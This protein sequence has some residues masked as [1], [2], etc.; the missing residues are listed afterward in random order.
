[1]SW[2][3]GRRYGRWEGRVRAPAADPSYNA[4]MLLWP[5]ADTWPAGGEIDFMVLS[6]WHLDHFWGIESTLKHNPRLTIYAPATWRPEDRLLL[7]EKGNIQVEDHQGRSISICRNDVPHEGELI[8][9]KSEGESGEGLYRLLPGVALRMFDALG[10]AGV[11]RI[12]FFLT[13]HGPVMNELNTMPGMTAQSQV[14]R[15]F[16]A[17]GL[18]GAPDTLEQDVK[19]ALAKVRLGEVDAALVYRTDVLA[20]GAD[21]R[22]IDFP[23]A[24]SAVND[25]LVALVGGRS[26]GTAFVDRVLSEQGRQ[27]LADTGFDRP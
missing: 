17:A 23:E 18:R 7:T 13:D 24:G 15:M 12:D 14:P 16:A 26:A 20:A 8:L 22:G 19:A 9:T 27:V 3:P 25:Y 21:V 10:C 6:H 11:A 5:D 4:V 1:M 2:G